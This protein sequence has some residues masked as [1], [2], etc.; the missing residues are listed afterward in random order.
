MKTFDRFVV[1]YLPPNREMLF[2][3]IQNRS[4]GLLS[5][6]SLCPSRHNSR[7]TLKAGSQFSFDL[8]EPACDIRTAATIIN[9]SRTRYRVSL[10][11]SVTRLVSIC[12][13]A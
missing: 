9:D 1:I 4:A 13:I 8:T 5:I 3:S 6:L 2:Y 7:R 10:R 11:V 12:V